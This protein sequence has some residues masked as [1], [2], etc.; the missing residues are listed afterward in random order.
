M[1]KSLIIGLS[2][3]VVLFFTFTLNAP[4]AFGKAKYKITLAHV[5]PVKSSIQ[6]GALKFKAFVEERT[7]GEVEVS[8]HPASELGAG[9]DLGQM[10]QTGAIQMSILP[11]AHLAGL[12]KEI[13]V[14]DI[15]FLLPRDLGVATNILNGPAGDKLSSYLG[16]IDLVGFAYYP[17]TFK[18]ITSNKPIRTPDDLKGVKFRVMPAP[19]L[20]ESYKLL[21]ASPVS[22][23]YHEVYTALQLGTAEGQENPIWT[24]GEMKFFEVQKYINMTNHG[25]IISIALANKKWFQGLPENIQKVIAKATKDVISPL[26]EFEEALDKEWL[27]KFKKNPKLTIIELTPGNI[28]A[29]MK[30]LGPVR[31]RYLTMVGEHGKDILKAY[32]D[33]VAKVK[34]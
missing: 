15:P 19:I 17:H 28:Q 21:G 8:V 1:K 5:E 11:G 9:P 22:I 31:D 2:L 30:A 7:Q 13:Q 16:K 24:I 26:V 33:A 34:K 27:E 4:M 6:V 20:V 32:D 29:F 23:S 25:S 14:L 10:T 12:F 18:Q 3:V